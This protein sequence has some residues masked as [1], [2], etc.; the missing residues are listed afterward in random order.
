MMLRI[1]SI[2][3]RK[4]RY[5]SIMI[6]TPSWQSSEAFSLMALMTT[7]TKSKLLFQTWT[8]HMFLLMPRPKP[9]LS[10]S[11]LRALMN[12]LLTMPLLMI[13]VVTESL[14]LLKAKSKPSRVV[15]VNLKMC[16]LWKRR[17]KKPPP[18]PPPVLAVVFYFS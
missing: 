6:L 1:G 5:E 18:P 17:M 2:R 9:Q 10:L 12:Y 14:I 16:R 15:P 8:C 11:T 3:R 13:L 4:M 7:S